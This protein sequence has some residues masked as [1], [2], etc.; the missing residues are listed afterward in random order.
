[1]TKTFHLYGAKVL[2]SP[3]KFIEAP[4]GGGAHPIKNH[5]ST[6][7]RWSKHTTFRKSVLLRNITQ[8]QLETLYITEV[9][10]LKL[11]HSYLHQ[12]NFPRSSLMENS[13]LFDPRLMFSRPRRALHN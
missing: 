10:R 12:L 3:W 8:K 1:M 9:M 7:S 2:A 6:V 13:V 11:Y 5:W 4:L